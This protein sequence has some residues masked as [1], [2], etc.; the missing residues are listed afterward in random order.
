MNVAQPL[1][2]PTE[3]P[4]LSVIESSPEQFNLSRTLRLGSFHIGSAFCDILVAS[5]WN[6]IMVTHIG[7]PAWPIALLLALR[8]LLFPLTIWAGY[9][10][11]SFP[12]R[13]LFRTPYILSGRLIM[14]LALPTLAAS[15]ACFELGERAFI[16]WLLAL[17]AFL[18]YGTGSLIS[19]SPYLAL[20]RES[21]PASHRGF[22]ITLAQTVMILFFPIAAITYGFWME[23]YSFAIFVELIAGTV[24]LA[25]V[26]WFGS[27]LGIEKPDFSEQKEAEQGALRDTL[28]LVFND[29]NSKR[30]FLVLAIASFSAWAQDAILE[31]FGGQAFNLTVGQTTRYNSYWLGATIICLLGGLIIWGRLSFLWQKRVASVGLF[32]MSLGMFIITFSGIWLNFNTYIIGLIT[33]GVGFGFYTLGGL[34]L[35]SSMT[36]TKHAGLSLALWSVAQVVFRGIGIGSGGI[37]HDIVKAITGQQLLGY[38]TVFALSACGLLVSLWFLLRIT[39]TSAPVTNN[40]HSDFTEA[41]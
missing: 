11:D 35:M 26:F 10:S 22:A 28:K 7:A 27:I 24:V 8:Y 39:D 12:W 31:P 16:G 21:A 40:E 2:Q 3:K 23:H 19:S 33:F 6:R 36:V 38:T 14:L 5:V 25:G 15:L 29:P 4:Q 17:F 18:L 37:M 20:V 32:I 13:G 30:F 9:Q 34:Q 41:F 1:K